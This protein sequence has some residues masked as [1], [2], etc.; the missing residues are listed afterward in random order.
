MKTKLLLAS[1]LALTVQ[2]QVLAQTDELGYKTV[3]LTM[4]PSYQNQVYF[5]LANENIKSQLANQWDIAFYRNSIMDMGIKVN[6]AKDIKVYQVS[7][8][9][10]AFDSIDLS[11]KSSWGDPLYNPDT[12]N[13]IQEGAFDNATLLPQGQ[14]NF[15]WGSYD[16]VTHIITGKVSF[17]LEY[18]DGSI[19]KF[20]INQFQGGYT[21]KYAKWNG[22]A[23]EAI[24]TKTVA[25]GSDD[26]YFN[27]FSF[28]SGEKV[29]NIEPAKNAWSFM[30]TRYYTFYNNIMMYR[31]SGVIQNPN[32]KVAKIQPEVQ[33]SATY[34]APADASY[35]DM[36]TSI[37]HSWKPTSGAY[38]DVVYYIKEGNQYYRLYFTQNGGATTGN[39]GFKYKNITSELGVTELGKKA[40]FGI[41]PNP[42]ID[43]KATILFD[44][45]E[46]SNSN[47]SAEIYDFSGKKVFE[48]KLTKQNGLHQ[49]D[50]N[51]S[52]LASGSYL[53]KINYA[54]IS[55][56]KKIIVK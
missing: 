49:Q 43:K 39:M 53:L 20:F 7:A 14:F 24:Q 51:L 4:G 19:Y 3:S 2:T 1:I 30:F 12:T 5:N 45:K 29:N 44:V 35:S 31:M 42:V 41:Y 23:W 11:Q 54:G 47:G 56:T 13:R 55:E 27:Y 8:T 26:A 34:A 10:S 48:T 6:D 40:S 17:V 52:Q 50:L 28:D 38:S 25:N 36:I 37:G 18:G 15:G 22:S 46:N 9:P 21:F 16:M 33:A 32:I